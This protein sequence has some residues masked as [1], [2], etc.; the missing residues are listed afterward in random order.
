MANI[1]RNLQRGDLHRLPEKGKIV[2]AIYYAK[3][4]G[5][6][7]KAITCAKKKYCLSTMFILRTSRK[8][9]F[10]TGWRSWSTAESSVSS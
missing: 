10:E 8:R 4:L 1:I 2:T 9:D 6:S 3:S 5:W 7:E